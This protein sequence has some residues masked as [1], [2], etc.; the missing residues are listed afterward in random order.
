MSI[1]V[2]YIL[3]FIVGYLL[4]HVISEDHCAIGTA[5]RNELFRPVHILYV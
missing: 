5:C 3:L 2:L 1:H 4:P